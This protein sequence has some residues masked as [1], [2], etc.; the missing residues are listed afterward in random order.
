M[1]FI[2]LIIVHHYHCRCHYF[3]FGSDCVKCDRY[4]KNILVFSY[5]TN[6]ISRYHINHHPKRKAATAKWVAN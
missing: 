4:P 2:A 6:L 5:H 1:L 3:F